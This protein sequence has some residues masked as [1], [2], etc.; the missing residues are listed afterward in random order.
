MA[1]MRTGFGALC[2]VLVL[3]AAGCASS[4]GQ[5]GSTVSLACQEQARNAASQPP[6]PRQL[7]DGKHGTE[8]EQGIRDA[9][10][11]QACQQEV[12]SHTKIEFKGRSGT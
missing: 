11:S 12:D 9:Q 2:G 1:L 6:F 3:S 8:F 5:D 7:R 4:I 10:M